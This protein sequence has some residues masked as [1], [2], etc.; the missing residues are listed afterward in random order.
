MCIRTPKSTQSNTRVHRH[1]KIVLHLC[2]LRNERIGNL[3]SKA[4]QNKQRS[5]RMQTQNENE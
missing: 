4:Y 3:M 2:K 5:S 1:I